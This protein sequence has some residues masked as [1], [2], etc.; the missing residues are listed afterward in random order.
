MPEND[1][2]LIIGGNGFLGYHIVDDLVQMKIPVAIFDLSEAKTPD[3]I[4][5][6]KENKV[7]VYLGDLCSR[8]DVMRAITDFGVTAVINTASPP[9]L[10]KNFS[11]FKKVNYEGTKNIIQC[12]QD[13]GVKKYVLT[14]S[15][16]VTECTGDIVKGTEE[17]CQYI[18]EKDP[19]YYYVSKMLQEKFVLS[20]NGQKGLM[21]CAIRPHRLWGPGDVTLMPAVVSRAGRLSSMFYLGDG[22]NLVDWTFVKNVS[23]ALILAAQK[24]TSPKSKPAGEVYFITN[25]EPIPFWD[26]I[27]NLW[28]GLGYRRPTVSVPLWIIWTLATFLKLIV[29]IL[30]LCFTIHLPVELDPGYLALIVAQRY[31]DI[32]KA[33]KDLGYKPKYT[34]KEGLAITLEYYKYLHKDYKSISSSGEQ[35][36]KHLPDAIDGETTK[37]PTKSPRSKSNGTRRRNSTSGAAVEE[38]KSPATSPRSKSNNNTKKKQ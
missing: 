18:S 27:G 14:S 11:L 33:K 16:G 4:K 24:L 7:K 12:C 6:I 3:Q 1:R 9:P 37:T 31:Y 38:S 10:S 30:S 34:M 35:K 19:N 25:D 28:E 32:S 13:A 36:S 21:T 5:L 29:S 17:S 20:S 8:D 23:Y 2:F 22:K 15:V 26:F